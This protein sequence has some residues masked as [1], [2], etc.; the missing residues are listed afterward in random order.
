[1]KKKPSQ[2]EE[3]YDQKSIWRECREEATECY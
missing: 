3:E 1:M 2:V